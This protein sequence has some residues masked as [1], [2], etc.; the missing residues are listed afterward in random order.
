MKML[1][2]TFLC[3]LLLGGLFSLVFSQSQIPPQP[4]DTLYPHKTIGELYVKFDTWNVKD[5]YQLNKNVS[6]RSPIWK[7][8]I[9]DSEDI[10]AKNYVYRIVAAFQSSDSAVFVPRPFHRNQTE[11]ILLEDDS[12]RLWYNQRMELEEQFRYAHKKTLS[13]LNVQ[14][15]VNVF[16]SVLENELNYSLGPSL[17]IQPLGLLTP[18]LQGLF[19]AGL[20]IDFP[21]QFLFN[22]DISTD[23]VYH[24]YFRLMVPIR[25]VAIGLQQS[26]QNS[27]SFNFS[28]FRNEFF[29][30]FGR[31][32]F[33][34]PFTVKLF[35]RVPENDFSL[36]G[37]GLSNTS[38]YFIQVGLNVLQLGNGMRRYARE[39]KIVGR[40]RTVP[41]E[42]YRKKA[43][44]FGL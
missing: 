23:P 20:G 37:E 4:I 26:S 38:N 19:S 15:N 40:E 17:Q 3:L 42:K 31:D 28:E 39:V 29:L 33:G 36:F 1:S 8:K 13:Y 21:S 18:K 16:E 32:G 2:H 10:R 24:T 43:A 5:L 22:N 11:R 25:T 35:Y 30:G 41:I 7:D 34:S 6:A 9:A 12:S 27:N 44:R 14:I